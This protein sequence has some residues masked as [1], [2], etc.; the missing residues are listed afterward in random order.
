VI[1]W[2]YAL[3]VRRR[4]ARA[5]EPGWEVTFSWYGPDGSIQDISGFG[6]TALTH[7]NTAGNQ[8]WE[9]VSVTEDLHQSGTAELHRYHMKRL[10]PAAAPRQRVRSTGVYRRR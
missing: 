2:E 4:Q 1:R 9:L 8:G 3:L 6:D 7:L 10:I 5:N